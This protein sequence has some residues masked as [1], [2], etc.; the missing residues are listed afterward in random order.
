MMKYDY[1]NAAAAK[2]I[3]EF[4][5]NKTFTRMDEHVGVTTDFAALS[6]GKPGTATLGDIVIF[7]LL[8]FGRDCYAFDA[9]FGHPNLTK[10]VEA[11]EKRQTAPTGIPGGVYP[12]WVEPFRHGWIDGTRPNRS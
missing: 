10:L 6:S 9:T 2:S 7:V 11:F 5:D 1:L 8:T 4:G 3:R 12:D